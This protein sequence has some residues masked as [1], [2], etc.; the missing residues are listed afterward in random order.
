MTK[1]RSMISAYYDGE[2]PEAYRQAFRQRLGSSDEALLAG[3]QD[4]SGALKASAEP[5]F[6]A[7]QARVR[8]RLEQHLERHPAAK[9]VKRADLWHQRL[10]LPL[11]LAAAAAAL[12]ILGS[13]LVG[14]TLRQ[15]NEQAQLAR[16][17]EILDEEIIRIEAPIGLN[18]QVGGEGLL[19][20]SSFRQE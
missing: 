19:M 1:D 12:L 9:P 6:Q 13:G 17:Q 7:A 16:A 18:L 11:P 3:L 8:A 20:L 14:F 5:D 10:S 4:L 15:Q 2:I